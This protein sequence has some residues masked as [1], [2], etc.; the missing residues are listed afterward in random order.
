MT[1]GSRPTFEIEIGFAANTLDVF[2]LTF[3]QI[4]QVV[5]EKT[6]DDATPSD[7]LLTFKL[8]QEDTLA[9]SESSNVFI[10]GRGRAGEDPYETEILETTVE[11]IL[12]DGVI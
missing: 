10:Q 6:L 3:V 5:L 7:T 2:Y 8:N 1:R 9:L 11:R 4:G 12:K